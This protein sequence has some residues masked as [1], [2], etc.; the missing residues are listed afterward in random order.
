MRWA[1]FWEESTLLERVER[2][3]GLFVAVL[4]VRGTGPGRPASH[5]WLLRRMSV[6][7]KR[8]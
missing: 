2:C 8:Q 1:L 6:Y 7:E 4:A 5:R 3:L